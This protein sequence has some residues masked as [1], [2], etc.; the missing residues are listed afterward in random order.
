MFVG[1]PLAAPGSTK[2]YY[3][4]IWEINKQ[5]SR[6]HLRLIIIRAYH[7]MQYTIGLELMDESANI[8]L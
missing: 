7:S 2:Y 3:D 5:S 8:F 1:Q 6:S 4:T